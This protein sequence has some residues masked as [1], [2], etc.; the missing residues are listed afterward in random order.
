MIALAGKDYWTSFD[1]SIIIS[2]LISIYATS[3][4][5][6]VSEIYETKR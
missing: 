1:E 6:V 3:T 4:Y 5:L 2:F